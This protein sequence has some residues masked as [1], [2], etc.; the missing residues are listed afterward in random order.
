[1]GVVT[2]KDDIQGKLKNRSV[3]C[4]VVGFSVNHANDVYWMLN[5][6]SKRII[7]TRDFFGQKNA[8][9]IGVK[10]KLIQT[11]MIKMKISEMPRKI[12]LH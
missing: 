7:Q 11:I 4:M 12:M 1:M 9:I 5:L 6:N 3:T 8:T 10:I 2:T